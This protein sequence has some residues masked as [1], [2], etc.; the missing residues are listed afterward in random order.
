MTEEAL[1]FHRP[2]HLKPILAT[3]SALAALL[4]A[5]C[6]VR[7]DRPLSRCLDEVDLTAL[8]QIEHLPTQTQP[9]FSHGSATQTLDVFDAQYQTT[10][11]L[12][13]SAPVVVASLC[14]RLEDH[15][16]E[17]CNLRRVSAGPAHCAFSVGSP[18]TAT[19]GSDGVHH[20]RRMR[21]HV[22][23]FAQP[24]SGGRT[25]LIVTATEWPG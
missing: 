3:T 22:N 10:L 1:M 2:R 16:A 11:E 4:V 5:G 7:D 8:D 20:H 23:L 17:R 25:E 13:D 9:S 18:H 19:T 6:V 21:G 15:L 14:Q 12:G 24:S